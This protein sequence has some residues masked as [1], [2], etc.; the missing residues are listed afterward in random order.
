MPYPENFADLFFLPGNYVLSILLTSV[1]Q[2][3]QVLGLGSDDY[4]GV[5]AGVLSAITWLTLVVLVGT[6]FE[7]LRKLNRAVTSRVAAAYR[8]SLRLTRLAKIWSISRVHRLKHA[9]RSNRTDAAQSV[10]THDLNDLETAALQ[11][12]AA[13]RPNYMMTATDL[14]HLLGVRLPVS[15][16]TLYKL[17]RLG[18]IH[19]SAGTRDDEAGYVI[20]RLGHGFLTALG[21]KFRSSA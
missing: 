7:L 13:L 3:A 20:S 17:H 10:E 1:P 21:S 19:R 12:H 11:A 18:L 2:L 9:M 5:L 14:A 6:A 15:Q 8:G 4:S 16:Q